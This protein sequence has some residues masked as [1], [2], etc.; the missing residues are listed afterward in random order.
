[1][2]PTIIKRNGARQAYAPQKIIT[3]MSKAFADTGAA[4]DLSLIHISFFS[5]DG[6]RTEPA[7]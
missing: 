4:V 3:A 6:R 1:M 7:V 2:E 5:L